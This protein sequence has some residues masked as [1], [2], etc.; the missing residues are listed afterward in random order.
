M[1]WKRNRHL[2][3][4]Q[5]WPGNVR[6]FENAM[7]RVAVLSERIEIDA[8]EL[9]SILDPSTRTQNTAGLP[10][11]RLRDLEQL[12]IDAALKRHDGNKRRAAEELGIAL[13]T[14]Y[15]KRAKLA[16]N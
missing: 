16:G 2:E 12:A 11:L 13:K 5:E 4:E 9:R 10:T 3:A 8:S 6:E 1:L 7:V 14:L 15:N